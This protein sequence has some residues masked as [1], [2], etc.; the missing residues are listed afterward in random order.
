MPYSQVEPFEIE[1]VWWRADAPETERRLPI[2]GEEP[3]PGLGQDEPEEAAEDPATSEDAKDKPTAYEKDTEE[4]FPGPW[5]AYGSL[6]F[7]PTTGL[8]LHTLGPAGNFFSNEGMYVVHGHALNG[9]PCSLLDSYVERDNSWT[10]GHAKRRLYSHVLVDNAHVLT[11]DE[12]HFDELRLEL[13]GLFEFFWHQG[14]GRPDSDDE[15]ASKVVRLPGGELTFRMGWDKREGGHRRLHE[16]RARLSIKLDEP[17]PYRHWMDHWVLPMRD[18]L[19]LATREP[20]RLESFVAILRDDD[21]P[22]PWLRV[23][24][25]EAW[26]RREVEFVTPEGNL[27][28][29]DPRFGYGRMLFGLTELEDDADRIFARWWEM[30]DQLAGARNTLFAALTT[31]MYLENQMQS[32]MSAAEA[33][34]RTFHDKQPL[35]DERHQELRTAMLGVTADAEERA[36]YESSLKYANSQ[37]QRKR[38]SQLWRRAAEVISELKPLRDTSIERLVMT[39]N[40]FTH[41]DEPDENV[42]EGSELLRVINQLVLVLQANILLDLGVDRDT[43]ERLLRRS[44]HGNELVVLRG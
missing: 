6:T 44:Y 5:P 3:E 31:R 43:A 35:S 41:L 12:L 18:L 39:R 34:H 40:Y 23:R 38:L 22:E 24:D 30:Y 26:R 10:S 19:T 25:E 36:V 15:T 21:P 17:A 33:Y 11:E 29:T 1:G 20:S 8:R 27:V 2:I 4:V 42:R 9:K 14:L 28:R 37:R 7:D 16:R 13:Q 32:M